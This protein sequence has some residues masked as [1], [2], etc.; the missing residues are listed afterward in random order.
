MKPRV[1]KL[2]NL[3]EK[4]LTH[5]HTNYTNKFRKLYMFHF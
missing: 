2:I 1:H 5:K 3:G 4:F